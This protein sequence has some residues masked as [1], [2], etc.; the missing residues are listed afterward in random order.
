MANGWYHSIYDIVRQ[1]KERGL[2]VYGAGFWGAIAYEIFERLGVSVLCYCDDAEQKQ[3]KMQKD[4]KIL[5]LKEAAEV[6]PDAVYIIAVEDNVPA[7]KRVYM[8]EMLNKEKVFSIYSGI[9]IRFYSYLLDINPKDLIW[10]KSEESGYLGKDKLNKLLILN[11]MSNSG[12]LYL[13][14]LLDGHPQLLM[15][16]GFNAPLRELY[17]NRFQFIEGNELIVEMMA[18]MMNQFTSSLEDS[19]FMHG[20][21][22]LH[23]RNE[24]GNFEKRVLIEPQQ[25]LFYLK[26][27]LNKDGKLTSFD[28]LIKIYY[29]V[30][31]CCIGKKVSVD[32][33]SWAVYH[34]HEF[35]TP[36]GALTPALQGEFE[37]VEN[38][39]IIREPVQHLH[40]VLDSFICRGGNKVAA[41]E[42][43]MTEI[44]K[45]DCGM[46]L[47]KREELGE[48]IRVIRF[49]DLKLKHM[50]TMRAFCSYYEIQYSETLE[51]TTANGYNIYFGSVNENGELVYLTGQNNLAVLRKDFSKTMNVFDEMRFNLAF[52]KF[53]KAYG[54]N[55]GVPDFKMLSKECLE[56]LMEFEF[57][58]AENMKKALLDIGLFH[59][60]NKRSQDVIKY[61]LLKFM[62]SYKDD[63]KYYE[64]IK[65]Q[66]KTKEN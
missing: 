17:E 24:K 58:C 9:H 15:I 48:G 31:N 57:K 38:L 35:R 61:I 51:N 28:E 18:Q 13:E 6:F 64:Y 46:K 14:Q 63:T 45:T 36:I 1:S 25:F 65:P 30:Y 3:G 62:L 34:M 50:E 60:E 16:P 39:V 12:S 4:K 56:E 29:T 42:E 54:Y 7:L 40:S 2:I 21:L 55:I 44:L 27:A 10:E 26:K 41:T 23:D 19:C 43:F 37:R 5:S 53:K 49:E 52:Q 47:E 20:S 11:H 59:R 32:G 22:L 33:E 66:E 8:Q